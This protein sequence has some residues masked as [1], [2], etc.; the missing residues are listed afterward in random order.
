MPSLL[1]ALVIIP[2]VLASQNHRRAHTNNQITIDTSQT[3]QQ[4]DGLGFSQAFQRS[5]QLHGLFGLSATNQTKVLDLLFS[6]TVGA[7][8]TIL[9]NGIGSSPNDT[10]DHMESIEP[11]SPGSPNSPPHYV[12]DGNDNS[13][14]WLSQQAMAYGVKYIYADAWSAPGYMKDNGTE[15]WGGHLCGVTGTNCTTGDWRQAFAN[16]LVQYLRFYEE[17]NI[18]IT[19]LGFLNEPDIR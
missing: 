3:Y 13:Q 9:R 14:V 18:T 15:T 2:L 6:N 5:N 17:A 16:Y 7:G 19:H 12:W 4:F 10:Y 1:L 8:L 11:V